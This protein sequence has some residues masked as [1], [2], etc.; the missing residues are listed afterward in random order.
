MADIRGTTEAQFEE[1]AEV[2]EKNFELHDEVGAGFSVY[3]EGDK[4]VDLT[5]GVA[6][7]R[8]A[9]T[10]RTPCRWCS[11]PPR[12]SPPCAPTCS[13]SVVSSTWTLRW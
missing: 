13:C 2:F 11:R 8:V 7:S 10:T 9:P 4:V 3:L 1:L 5:G 6:N 12:A